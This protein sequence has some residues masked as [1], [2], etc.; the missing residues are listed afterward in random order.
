MTAIIEND[1]MIWSLLTAIIVDVIASHLSC[2]PYG[3]T[4]LGVHT[5]TIRTLAC[6]CGTTGPMHT[7]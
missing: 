6:A 3:I 2:N 5:S 1:S 7:R 4:V